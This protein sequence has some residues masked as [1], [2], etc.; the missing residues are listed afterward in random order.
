VMLA[1]V[2]TGIAAGSLAASF[3]MRRSR[4]ADRH[5]WALALAAGTIGIVGY[6]QLGIALQLGE[7]PRFE[8]LSPRGLLLT[9]TLMFPVSLL[10][11]AL[12]TLL[13]KALNDSLRIPVQSAGLLA[14][15]NTIGAAI[16]P[17]IAGFIMLPQLGIE[18]S[19]WVLCAGYGVVAL[20][21]ARWVAL[22]TA[23][24]AG[25]AAVAYVLA[26]VTYPFGLMNDRYIPFVTNPSLARGAEVVAQREGLIETIQLGRVS[27]LGE[28]LSYQLITNGY[29]MSGT[30]TGARRYMNLFV[31][32]PVALHTGPK[33]ALLISY[34]VGNT[35][36]ALTRVEGIRSI[37]VVDISREILDLSEIVYPDVDENPLR[38]PR[39]RVH[40]E[41]GRYFLQTTKQN[42]D[43]ITAEPPPPNIGHVVY[44]Y[45][46]EYFQLAHDRLRPG[47]LVSYWLP[48]DQL[49]REEV[50]SVVGAFCGVFEN[51]SLWNGGGL[52]WILVG[53]RGRL[54]PLDAD[55]FARQWRNESTAAHL[56]AI[57]VE[58]PEA[59]GALF[60]ADS[61]Q[62]EPLM[63]LAPPVR[64]EYPLRIFNRATQTQIAG[65]VEYQ[66]PEN[67]RRRFAQSAWIRRLWPR[68]LRHETLGQ[69]GATGT[70]ELAI[71]YLA[72]SDDRLRLRLVRE[73]LEETTL[74]TVPLLMLRGDPMRVSIAQRVQAESTPTP[75]LALTLAQGALARRE[76]AAAA[77]HYSAAARSTSLRA[78][79]HF[80]VYAYCRAGNDEATESLRLGL[81]D[82]GF[83]PV[84]QRDAREQPGIGGCWAAAWD[85][86]WQP[87]HTR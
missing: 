16:G 55:A 56:R 3:W 30:A 5:I 8:I 70:L 36:S 38:D 81:F 2:L 87:E 14:L 73:L 28:P 50:A 66:E 68:T 11:G 49:Q 12:F 54:A 7:R 51:C 45:T 48:V 37:D 80:A 18:R 22:R 23:R 40:I 85:P 34:G 35:A 25:L 4:S 72:T 67:C 27:F 10:S 62:L 60:M 52:N 43:L 29:P 44:L 63:A 79:R 64:D 6:A 1:V 75:E 39:V 31:N 82:D 77:E 13:G 61:E 57:A 78:Q 69:F 15:A 74:E 86:E 9:T 32:I 24:L 47:G 41:D 71:G 65:A 76:W 59:L 42:Y 17:L 21:S 19:I 84:V 53:S 46:Q 58:T 20:L 33:D 83:D 26:I